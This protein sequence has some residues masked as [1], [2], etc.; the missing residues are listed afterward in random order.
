MLALTTIQ[1]NEIAQ[2]MDCSN[3]CYLNLKT[4]ELIFTPD[5][6]ENI[7]A[8]REYYEEQLEELENNWGDYAEIEKP[9]SK[10]SF[11]IMVDFAEQLEENNQLKDKLFNALN[12][13]KPFSQFKFEIDNSGKYRQKWFDFK[14]AKLENWVIEKFKEIHND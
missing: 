10:D 12:K 13:K 1:I 4:G 8:D 9:R 2:E 3:R 14:Q 5:F 6:D 7:Y 11:D